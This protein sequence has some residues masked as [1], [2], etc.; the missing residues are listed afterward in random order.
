M[1]KGEGL[2]TF[3]TFIRMKCPLEED[4]NHWKKCD[5][6]VLGLSYAP[7]MDTYTNTTLHDSQALNKLNIKKSRD[8]LRLFIQHSG[9]SVA[10]LMPPVPSAHSHR[11]GAGTTNLAGQIAYPNTSLAPDVW[12]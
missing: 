9:S 11:T 12:S 10:K 5:H 1:A 2:E 6:S 4:A 7:W 3:H 8:M